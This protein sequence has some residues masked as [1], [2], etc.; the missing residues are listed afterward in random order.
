[1]FILE[2][3]QWCN[4]VTKAPVDPGGGGGHQGRGGGIFSRILGIYTKNRP[5][6]QENVPYLGQ[7]SV[8]S[9]RNIWGT[10]S[11]RGRQSQKNWSGMEKAGGRGMLR[12]RKL[13]RNRPH[14]FIIIVFILN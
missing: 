10:K 11:S 5:I 13:W 14:F 3:Y 7:L 9:K 1:M 2:V 6:R 4:K 12:R 8:Q